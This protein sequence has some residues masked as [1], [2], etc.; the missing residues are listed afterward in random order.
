MH[1]GNLAGVYYKPNSTLAKD[2]SQENGEYPVYVYE[3]Q[4]SKRY[5]KAGDF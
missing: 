3:M 2:N 4:K 5:G 1:I